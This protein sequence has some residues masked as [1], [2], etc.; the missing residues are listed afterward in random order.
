MIPK[1]VAYLLRDTLQGTSDSWENF[2]KAEEIAKQAAGSF[3]SLA[4]ATKKRRA[5][6]LD[7]EMTLAASSTS[8]STTA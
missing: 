1:Q 5:I 4:G 2:V 7:A 6:L 8:T 3:A